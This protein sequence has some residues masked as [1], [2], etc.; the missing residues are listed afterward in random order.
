VAAQFDAV[1]T[2]F[3]VRANEI[4]SQLN[5]QQLGSTN[6]LDEVR[7][8]DG[9]VESACCCWPDTLACSV[10]PMLFFCQPH[11][12]TRQ[13]TPHTRRTQAAAAVAAFGVEVRALVVSLTAGASGLTPEEVAKQLPALK[14]SSG[15]GSAAGS[16]S[17][18][19]GVLPWLQLWATLGSLYVLDL[20]IKSVLTQYAIKF[21]SALVGMFGV[22]GLLC[23][24]GDGTAN[25]IL[26]FYSPALNW[27]ARW[28]PIFYVPALVTLPLALQGIPGR[29][30]RVCVLR[31]WLAR[32]GSALVLP[33]GL[34]PRCP[35]ALPS[36]PPPPT[37]PLPLQTRRCRPPA[38]RGHPV[39]R[40][41]RHTHVH[42]ANHGRDS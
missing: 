23:A 40:H 17:E 14:L 32:C 26:A 16:A 3:V 21:P 11:S 2:K 12:P 4:R 6:A 34:V 20:G 15:G 24:V 41:G 10:P 18:G 8:R 25:K 36:P 28:L 33:G 39:C 31:P 13:H 35:P 7:L 30:V 38:H 27:I 19:G 1:L 29:R 42:R 9:V 37:H 5:S 22:F